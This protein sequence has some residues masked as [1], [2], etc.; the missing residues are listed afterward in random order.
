MTAI[1]TSR[2]GN[3]TCGL[4][5]A[6]NKSRNASLALVGF[7][8]LTFPGW[9]HEVLKLSPPLIKHL[10]L[11][12]STRERLS[13]GLTTRRSRTALQILGEKC[14]DQ[15]GQ[16]R[17]GQQHGYQQQPKTKSVVHFLLQ[18]GTGLPTKALDFR[19]T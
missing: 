2:T 11:C 18:I 17:S 13:L 10:A 8:I 15:P 19:R 1:A 14:V 3:H 9:N 16:H 12:W 6:R 7:A 5:W 4:A